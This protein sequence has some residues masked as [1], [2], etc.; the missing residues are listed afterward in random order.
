MSEFN[1]TQISNDYIIFTDKPFNVTGEQ[2]D[3]NCNISNYE[4]YFYL[5][6]NSSLNTYY[7]LLVIDNHPEKHQV[8]IQLYDAIVQAVSY[9][10]N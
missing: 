3:K 2:I 8:P 10:T 4:C 5:T 7:T 9:P 1:L 6:V